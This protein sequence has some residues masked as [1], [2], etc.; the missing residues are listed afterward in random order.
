MAKMVRKQIYI[1]DRQERLLR[2]IAETRGVSQAE[3]VR[4]AIEGQ[5]A[6]PGSAAGTNPIAWAQALDFMRSLQE[7]SASDR[8]LHRWSREELYED[9]LSGHD[10][11]PD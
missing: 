1:Q 8:K 4:Q 3:V 6:G 10:R 11:D 2:R 5:A 9:R 7:R